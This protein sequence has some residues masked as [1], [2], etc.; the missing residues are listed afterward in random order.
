MDIYRELRQ[1]AVSV[2]AREIGLRMALGA[3]ADAVL[4]LIL[5]QGM[6]PLFLGLACGLFAA[7]FFAEALAAH[8]YEVAPTDGATYL[9]VSLLFAVVGL[10][11]AYIPAR[12]A[13]RV[14]P[15]TVLK[16]E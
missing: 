11:A 10:A 4:V 6:K 5:H 9:A 8:L 14:D 12:R 1:A 7:Y 2:R 3:H 16:H 13:A 15:L